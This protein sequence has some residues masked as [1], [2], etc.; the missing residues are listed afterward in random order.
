MDKLEYFVSGL[1]RDFLV[2]SSRA[3]G[4]SWE[5]ERERREEEGGDW[6][7]EILVFW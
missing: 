4:E 3:F 5:R 2:E 7:W 1:C 6:A